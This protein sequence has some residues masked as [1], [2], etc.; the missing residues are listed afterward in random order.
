MHYTEPDI[1]AAKLIDEADSL[2]LPSSHRLGRQWTARRAKA[3]ALPFA[4]HRASGPRGLTFSEFH[5]L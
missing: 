5:P 4:S 1:D 2:V 3:N